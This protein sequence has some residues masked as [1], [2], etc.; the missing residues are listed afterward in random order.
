M[1]G[2]WAD[3]LSLLLSPPSTRVVFWVPRVHPET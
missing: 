3:P 2:V 1:D